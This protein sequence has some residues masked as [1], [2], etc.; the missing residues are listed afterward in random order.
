MTAVE[1]VL[2]GVLKITW[3]DGYEAVVDLLPIIAEGE[4]L[5]SFAANLN[6]SMQLS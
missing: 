2:Y 5:L 4:L 3:S 1:P 6:A